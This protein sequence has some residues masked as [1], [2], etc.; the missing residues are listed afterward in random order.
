MLDTFPAVIV[1]PTQADYN[2]AADLR[3]LAEQGD[4]PRIY[5]Q[6][7]E[8]F[9]AIGFSLSARRMRDRAAYYRSI[10]Q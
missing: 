1:V 2:L 4:D 3:I 8:A 5:E 6:A 10:A 7:A 9:D